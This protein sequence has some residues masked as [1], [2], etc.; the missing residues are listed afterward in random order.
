VA[1][2]FPASIWAIIPMFRTLSKGIMRA[3]VFSPFGEAFPGEFFLG[4]VRTT[5]PSVIIVT[6]CS[7]YIM[8]SVDFSLFMTIAGSQKPVCFAAI[9]APGT[10]KRSLR[11]LYREAMPYGR[12]KKLPAVMSKRL[13]GFCHLMSIFPFLSRISSIVGSIDE[14]SCQ[15][16]R[17]GFLRPLPGIPHQPS[18][19]KSDASI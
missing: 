3:R 10:G 6:R 19:G 15:S 5:A 13:V 2:V 14:L 9:R 4:I 7:L 18:H 1:V 17:H 12:E 16:F 8:H 11:G